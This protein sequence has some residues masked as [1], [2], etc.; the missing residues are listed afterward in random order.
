MRKRLVCIECP[1]GCVLLVEVEAG[2]AAK[3]EGGRCP[4]A[5]TW[6]AGEIENP[7]RTLTSTV[8]AADLGLRMVPVRTDRPIPQH[9]IFEAMEGVRKIVIDRPVSCGDV[10][11]QNFLGLG[12]N[13]IAT[14][15]VS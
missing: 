13:L 12:V 8:A 11:A 14:R 10:V 2:R 1:A 7:V 4:K 9:K 6:A 15:S 5:E 3:V